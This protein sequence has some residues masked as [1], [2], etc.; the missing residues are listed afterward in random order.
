MTA[1]AST[2]L[3]RTQ[4]VGWQL[5]KGVP[6][7]E[8]ERD[9]QL[10]HLENANGRLEGELEGFEHFAFEIIGSDSDIFFIFHFP[11]WS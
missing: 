5:D 3:H 10:S 1:H 7:R 8:G 2:H 11:S 6:F 4:H 9:K